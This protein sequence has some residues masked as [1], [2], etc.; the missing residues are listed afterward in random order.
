VTQTRAR[1][2]DY[3]LAALPVFLA[4]LLLYASTLLPDVGLW[5]TA[6]FQTVGSVLGIAHP[7]GYP[8]YTLMAWLASVVLGPFGNEAWRADLLSA[9][10]M[11]GA[12][13]LL[14]IRVVQAT[15]RWPLGLLAGVAFAVAPVA[16]KWGVRADPHAL[17]VFLAALILVLLA[18]W[19]ARAEDG[20]ARSGRWLLT[21]AVVFGL[22]L[23]NHALTLLLAPG[24]AVYVVAVAPRILWRQWRLVLAC[25][26]ALVLTTALVY[27]YL[28]LRSAMDP[29]LDYADPETWERFRYVVFG[30]QFRGSFGPLPPLAD[31]TAGGWDELVRNLGLLSILAVAGALLGLVRHPR[32]TALSLLWFGCTWLFAIGYPNAAIERYYLV[33]LLMAALW[34]GLAADAVWD[35][36][37]DLLRARADAG[38]L[39]L[40]VAASAGVLL[41]ASLIPVL[42]RYE[43]LD[44]GDETRGR[45][46][47]EA[48]FEALEPDAVVVS[49]WSFSTPLWYGRWVEGRREDITIIDD[50][51]IIDDG[52]GDVGGAIDHFLGERPVYVIRIKEDL[53]SLEA[54]YELEPVPAVPAEAPLVPSTDAPPPATPGSAEA[55][56][57]QS[58]A[59]MLRK[60]FEVDPLVCRRCGEEMVIVA[61]ITRPDVVDRILRHRR[62]RGLVSPFDP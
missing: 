50:R 40:A 9:L 41:L 46:Y 11:A 13:A 48:T 56:R 39:R 19:G 31:I 23:G 30:E 2:A 55:R 5:D 7:T 43:A 28:P 49:W 37:R 60:V 59:K 14:A 32:L 57:R 44:A 15:R 62:E 53:E 61:W 52:Y 42:D 17:H 38:R 25:A 18:G 34:V 35:A 27:L 3:A 21:S 33:P 29:P 58:W 22:A 12:A 8:T 10:V 26:G 47:L 6:E 4:A 24:I 20:G 16:W 54:S 45:E 36:L 1:A 51:D